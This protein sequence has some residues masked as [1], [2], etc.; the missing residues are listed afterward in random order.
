MD[1][2]WGRG[3]SAD[4]PEILVTREFRWSF[5]LRTTHCK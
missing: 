3:L 5:F 4:A 1:I 2:D